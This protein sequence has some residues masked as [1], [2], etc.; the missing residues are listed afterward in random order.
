[1]QLKRISF[2][3]LIFIII[4]IFFLCIGIS[5]YTVQ[6]RPYRDKIT[7][8]WYTSQF[9]LKNNVNNNQP[10]NCI[11]T[12]DEAP[13]YIGHVFSMKLFKNNYIIPLILILNSLFIIPSMINLKK[14]VLILTYRY[15]FLYKFL[16]NIL[17][18]FDFSD[19]IVYS[20]LINICITHDLYHLYHDFIIKKKN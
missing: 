17:H 8:K 15:L 9:I 13:C 5:N 10:I 18:N 14:I 7:R 19:H 16:N 2:I 4:T 6:Y 11:K 20:I 12:P 1:M 3:S